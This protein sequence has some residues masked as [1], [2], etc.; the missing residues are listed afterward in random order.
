[1]ECLTSRFDRPRLIHQ[2][3]VK[4]IL[5]SPQLHDGN[6]KEL[7]RLHDTV[8]QHVRALKS[9][10]EEPS[11]SFITSIIELKLDATTMFEWQRHT[12]SQSE[13]PHY[14]EILKFLDFRAQALEISM[15]LKKQSARPDNRN[16]GTFPNSKTVP[17]CAIKLDSSNSQCLLCKTE[18]H[19]LYSCP[20]FKS[21]PHDKKVSFVKVNNL[22]MNCLGKGH[23]V[24]DCKSL[25]RCK[26]CQNPHHTALHI[27]T[28]RRHQFPGSDSSTTLPIQGEVSANTAIKLKS[29]SF[30]MT[31][32]IRIVSPNGSSIEARALLD[33]ALS[34]SFVSE[35]LAQ[36][37][38]LKHSRQRISVSGIGGISPQAPVQSVTS[39]KILPSNSTESTCMFEVTALVVPRVTCDLPTCSVPFNPIWSHL[40]DLPLAD[41]EFGTPGRVDVL[42]G[43]DVFTNVLLNGRRKGPPGSPVSMETSFGW[44]LC[45]SATSIC[46]SPTVTTCHASVETGDDL[47]RKFLEIDEP[48]T[49]NPFSIDENTVVNHF[50]MNHVRKQNG[51]FLVPLPKRVDDRTLGSQ[52]VRRFLSLERTLNNKNRF[53]EL[54]SVIQARVF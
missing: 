21:L 36:T 54:D 4:K 46:H 2:T 35:R 47:L 48:P 11:L 25:Y 44:V 28:S 7:R 16:K 23:F 26:R 15:P 30:L 20:R 34:A 8:Q 49:L 51:R 40:I 3:H 38:Q 45:G 10:S 13:I 52:A 33:S 43:V 22:C 37:L 53:K 18:K 14:L 32:R 29:S 27:D 31:C 5:E 50:K 6:S 12:Q 39:F 42:L 19:P 17:S 41:P 1:M 9:M 24:T